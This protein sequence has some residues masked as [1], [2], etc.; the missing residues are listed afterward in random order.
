M[1]EDEG[2]SKAGSDA[3]EERLITSSR[4]NLFGSRQAGR[5]GKPILLERLSFADSDTAAA[6]VEEGKIWKNALS[7]NY[8][9]AFLN[10]LDITADGSTVTVVFEGIEGVHL[11]KYLKDYFKGYVA[12][13]FFA[14]EVLYTIVEIVRSLFSQSVRSIVLEKITLDDIFIAH[15]GRLK[16]LPPRMHFSD[17]REEFRKSQSELLKGFAEF[18]F[19]MLTLEDPV[20]KSEFPSQAREVN[21]EMTPNAES[22]IRRCAVIEGEGGFGNLLSLRQ[23]LYEELKR[24]SG[25]KPLKEGYIRNFKSEKPEVEYHEHLEEAVK[26]EEEFQEK[27]RKGDFGWDYRLIL[28][29][30]RDVNRQFNWAR[31]WPLFILPYILLL[32]PFILISDAR[33]TEAIIWLVI[34][35]FPLYVGVFFIILHGYRR[36]IE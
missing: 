17:D 30:F 19:F 6:S 10:P 18:L 1:E 5:G 14:L 11:P 3:V 32:L 15:D 34:W 31:L 22:I 27:V 23:G 36:P 20:K 21:M 35:S 13:E 24:Q 29:I 33:T 4:R 8:H 2:L 28:R 12:E 16:I 26:E 25:G 9:P 7:L